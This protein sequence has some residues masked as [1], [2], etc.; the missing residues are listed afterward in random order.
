M[1]GSGRTGGQQAT[2]RSGVF[3]HRAGPPVTVSTRTDRSPKP[4]VT[5]ACLVGLVRSPGRTLPDKHPICGGDDELVAPAERHPR[6]TRAEWELAHE[7]DTG[8]LQQPF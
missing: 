7:S 5:T 4:K 3:I 2:N 1:A 8:R 6:R